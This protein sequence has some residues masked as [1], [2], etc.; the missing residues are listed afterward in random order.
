MLIESPDDQLHRIV[1][2]GNQVAF[3]AVD[4]L[5]P[6]ALQ[7][8]EHPRQFRLLSDP[9]LPLG[10][11]AIISPLSR[12]FGARLQGPIEAVA[13]GNQPLVVAQLIPAI[14][15]SQLPM[16][17]LHRM[18]QTFVVL[19]LRENLGDH[20]GIVSAQVGDHDPRMIPLDS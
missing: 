4:Q 2:S 12:A 13:Q 10:H 18:E 7:R 1:G 9:C 6:M 16:Q 5:R 15:L 19:G 14:D 3:D 17:S 8:A 20:R 11:E